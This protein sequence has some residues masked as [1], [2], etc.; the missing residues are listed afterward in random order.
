MG[1]EGC[2][3]RIAMIGQKRIP[4]REGGVEVVVEELAVRMV[5][6]GHR[7]TCYNRMGRSVVPR[8]YRGVR[9][10][11]VPTIPV[12]GLAAVTSAVF[13]AVAAAFGSYDVVHFHAEGP[14]LLC[15][16]PRLM[17]KRVIVTVH[18]LDHRREKWGRIA[19]A[20]ILMGERSAAR[21]ASEIIVLSKAAQAYFMDTYGRQTRFIPNGIERESVRE[22]N[23]IT[24]EFGLSRGS[25]ILFLGRIVPEKGVRRLIEAFGRVRTEKRLVIAG[26]PSDTEAFLRELKDAARE[27][28][29]ILFTG[30]VQ[31]R[32]R[33]ELY[34]NAYVY[35]LPSDVEGMPLSLMEAMSY[36]NCC[37]VS[38]IPECTE[39]TEDKAVIFRRE[40]ADDLERNLQMLCDSPEVVERYR[41]IVP[42]FILNRY[43][44]E[45]TVQRT[46]ALYRGEP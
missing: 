20:C 31:G 30:F 25:Y 5:S 41:S 7:V 9:L 16:L 23:W 26:G 37:L 21:F 32:M 38:D 28:G 11:S 17:G 43:S 27:D 14:A 22:A 10:R 1:A 42:A 2:G 6:M 40:D 29:R 15:W 13:G 8:E 46:L 4:S 18:G 36:G 34:S 33:G 44:W 39:V 45:K 35:V 24:R 12:R 19:R 3:L